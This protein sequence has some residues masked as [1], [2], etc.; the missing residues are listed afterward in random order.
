[1][2]TLTG[3][4]LSA[5]R[6]SLS[7]SLPDL[8][9]R[10]APSGPALALIG[11]VFFVSAL[12]LSRPAYGQRVEKLLSPEALNRLQV[13]L[14]GRVVE[15]TR[16]ATIRP[17]RHR[18]TPPTRLG[19]GVLITP[20]LILT[21]HSWTTRTSDEL[22][23]NFFARCAPLHR[24]GAP[25]SD[26]TSTPVTSTPVTSILD[27]PQLGLSALQLKAP[28][29][30]QDPTRHP[31]LKAQML[32]RQLQE[33]KDVGIFYAGRAFFLYEALPRR[34][35]RVALKYKGRSHWAYYWLIDGSVPEGAPL[36]DAQG[37][38][39]TLVTGPLPPW[40]R[41]PSEGISSLVLP[42]RAAVSFLERM[43]KEGLTDAGGH[44]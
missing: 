32:K 41:T 23:V 44:R 16:S 19:Q 9:M 35:A 28:L 10:G 18:L 31:P 6:G 26:E 39:A 4:A 22:E 20:K 17:R 3:G 30:C 33:T 1:M 13:A 27:D 7:P 25:S 11:C 38:W 40:G 21:A 2:M 29:S 36:F 12:N 43:I 5:Q 14:K 15:L 37:R 24:S 42:N 8:L 34:P